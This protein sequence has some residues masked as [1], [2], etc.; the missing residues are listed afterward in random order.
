MPKNI[1]PRPF[2]AKKIKKQK[3]KTKDSKQLKFRFKN[4]P[5][6]QQLKQSSVYKSYSTFFKK[7]KESNHTAYTQ[8][9]F[10][11]PTK[12]AV[13]QNLLFLNALEGNH[14]LYKFFNIAHDN[15]N[16]YVMDLK[17]KYNIPNNP[18]SYK[19][20]YSYLLENL[21][22][23]SKK[24]TLEERAKLKFLTT[25][26]LNTNKLGK[27]NFELKKNSQEIL[28]TKKESLKNILKK[29]EQDIKIAKMNAR[30]S[31]QDALE[32]R[33]AIDS[34]EKYYSSLISKS[35]GGP[36]KIKAFQKKSKLFFDLLIDVKTASD[37]LEKYHNF[38]NP[39]K[40]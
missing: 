8:K 21:S 40:K 18:F 35:S 27:M 16:T 5:E 36:E 33:E 6:A 2:R 20:T 26:Y 37:F 38:L 31:S 9:M 3:P 11:K 14:V 34:I 25:F 15:L 30:Y 12:K 1:N 24:L 28:D 32:A 4:L 29:K 13:K 22:H 23:F 7:R 17:G 39:I 10:F 19:N